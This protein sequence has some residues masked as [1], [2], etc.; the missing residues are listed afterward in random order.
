MNAGVPA[1]LAPVAAWLLRPPR[2]DEPSP[3]TAAYR[4]HDAAR[5]ICAL[6][7]VDVSVA[8]RVPSS[9]AL[10]VSNHLGYL[11]PIVLGAILPCLALAKREVRSWPVLG[12]KLRE[13]GVLFVDRGDPISGARALRAMLRAFAVGTSVLNFPEGTTSDGRA[14]LPFRRGAFGAARIARVPIVPVLVEYD[15]AR[16]AW[17]GD[18]TFLPHY[19]ALVARGPVRARVCFGRP[20]VTHHGKTARALAD[21]ARAAIEDLP[22]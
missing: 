4:Q 22:A 11:D 14:L 2:R 10:L 9:P 16:V 1:Q 3:V 15:D 13:L 6:H 17:V 5:A 8:G 7:R 18:A 19:A 12:P 20:I 21:E